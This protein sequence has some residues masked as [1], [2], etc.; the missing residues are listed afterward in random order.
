MGCPGLPTPKQAPGRCIDDIW[1]H[2]T[3]VLTAAEAVNEG[4]VIQGGTLKMQLI[5]AE[6]WGEVN[7]VCEN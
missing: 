7:W 5:E 3:H 2:A 4:T 1:R 6:V